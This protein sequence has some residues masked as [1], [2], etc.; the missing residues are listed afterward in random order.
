MPFYRQQTFRVPNFLEIHN[1]FH[2]GEY[3]RV[4]CSTEGPMGLAALYLK[5][6]Y[7]VKAFFY[8]HTDWIM[9]AKKVLVMEQANL[10]RFRRLLRAYYRE[11]D[12]LFVLNKDQQK[13]LTGRHMGLDPKQVFLTAH[14]ADE[15]FYR[16]R[17]TKTEIFDLPL[18]TNVLL[19]AGRISLEKGVMEIPEIFE[20][21]RIKIPNLKMVIAGTGPALDDLR[22]ALPT[23]TYLGWIDHD[24][25]PNVYSA[26][27]LIILPS[28]FDTF[29]CVVLE[30]M[31]CGLPVIAYNTK[32]PKDII[33][34]GKN[35]FVV[36]GK[37]E[38]VQQI[39]T[40]FSNSDLPKSFRLSAVKRA[41]SYSKKKI[42]TRF[43]ADAGL[44]EN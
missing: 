6:A 39:T 18:K 44:P 3:D 34:N 7:S 36:S 13:W 20:Q 29:S 11:F 9:F 21:V 10:S 40:F 38:M 15:K 33:E 19:F 23:A 43:L 8:L 32:G 22:K 16:R 31:S 41:K 5:N 25:L 2:K 28:R 4:I 26:S 35:G 27:D 1:L 24:Q 42:L 17:T 12:G 30:A 14:W 37:Q